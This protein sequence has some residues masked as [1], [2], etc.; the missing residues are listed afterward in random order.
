MREDVF[1]VNNCR[2]AGVDGTDTRSLT[3]AMVDGR[4]DAQEFLDRVLRSHYPG[5]K[6]APAASPS[7]VGIRETRKIVGEYA[8]TGQDCISA[9]GSPDTISLSGCG[10]GLPDPERPS[11]QPFSEELEGKSYPHVQAFC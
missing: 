7:V 9:N 2:Q 11:L 6:N 10:W 1:M 8:L 3:C 4:R 5:L